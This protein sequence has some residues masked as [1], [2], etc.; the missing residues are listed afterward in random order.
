MS[1]KFKCPEC[2]GKELELV[3]IGAVLTHKIVNLSEDGCF[4]YAQISIDDGETDRFQCS[5]CGYV[6]CDG[7][8]VVQDEKGVVEWLKKN[9][10]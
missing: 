3:E 1:L 9:C 8:L 2:S 5:N 4:E 7:I 10:E 6:L